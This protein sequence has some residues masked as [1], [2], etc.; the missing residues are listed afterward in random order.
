MAAR[1]TNIF[2][3]ML[4]VYLITKC[5]GKKQVPCV[6]FFGDSL[7]DNGN[8]NFL[9]TAAKANHTPY[10]IDYPAGPTGRF[11]NGKNIPDFLAKS[12]GFEKAIPPFAT[13]KGTKILK[14]VNYGSGGGGIL[15]ESGSQ[16]G[17]VMSMKKQLINHG[18]TVADMKLLLGSSG[19]ARVHLNKCLY[20]SNMGNNDYINNYLSP[21][22]HLSTTLYTPQKF[23]AILTNQYRRQL[24]RLYKYGARKVAIYGVGS[25]G[26]LPQFRSTVEFMDS[27]NQVTQHFN[28]RLATLVQGLNARLSGAQFVFINTTN[29][30]LGDPSTLGIKVVDNPCC[31][32]SKQ[33][34]L[35]DAGKKPCHNRNEYYFWDNFHPT[36]TA[37]HAMAIRSY[38][39]ASPADAYPT[40]I[41][42]LV[43]RN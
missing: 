30:A 5:D 16:L 7:T 32:V 28:D 29:I 17:D 36:E 23:A 20:V 21:K 24:R 38:A 18:K 10:G 1:I 13:A 6:F 31:V 34:G 3:S 40:D 39:A 37:N 19:R 41:R 35:C 15:D 8:N 9:A 2:Y 11:S 22:Y 26:Y 27:T 42:N 14:G 4:L 12:L 43:R 25:I 33:T